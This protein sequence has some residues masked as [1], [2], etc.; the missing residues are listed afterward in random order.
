MIFGFSRWTIAG[1][2][3]YIGA[4]VKIEPIMKANLL[5]LARA[6]VGAKGL[7]LASL[8]RIAHGDWPFFERLVEDRGSISARKY[9]EVM[10]WFVK[11]WPKD[12][13]WPAVREIFVPAPERAKRKP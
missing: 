1:Q 6:Y 13:A 12:L 9:D 10:A 4:M 5:L 8:A 3:R 11:N 2:S 7:S